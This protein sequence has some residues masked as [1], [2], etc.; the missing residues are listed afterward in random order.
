MDNQNQET[1][2][3]VNAT[4]PSPPPPVPT[5]K[6]LS[7]LKKIFIIVVGTVCLFGVWGTLFPD[8]P[9]TP[10]V[11]QSARNNSNATTST[12]ATGVSWKTYTNAY[13][14]YS[15]TYPDS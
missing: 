1:S 6:P 5:R 13:Y 2:A 7:L 10:P 12:P 4:Q 3:P 9:S 11:N 14:H 8:K 15:V